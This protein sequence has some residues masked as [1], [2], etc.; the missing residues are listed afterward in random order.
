M[1]ALAGSLV[2]ASSSVAAECPEE[3]TYGNPVTPPELAAPGFPDRRLTTVEI[4]DYLATV[5]EESDRVTTDTY[6]TS[7]SGTDL[8]YALVGTPENLERVEEIAADQKRLRDPRVTDATTAGTIADENPA[9]VWYAGNIHGNETS[10]ADAAVSILYDLA[11]RTDCATERLLDELVIGI[12]PTQNPDGRD[13]F[14]RTNTYKFDMNRD[15]FAL[16]QPATSGNV[17]LL[18]AYPPVLFIDAHE[19]GSSDYFFPPNADP[20][21]HE[22]SDESL[23]WINDLYGPALADAFDERQEEQPGQWEYFSYSVYDL[24]YM[25]YGDTVPTTAFTS[26]GMTFEK[27]IAD[28]DRQR[29]VEQYV[30]GWTSLE[31]AAANKDDILREY[32][33]AHIQAIADG[34]AGRLEDNLVVQPENEVQFEVPDDPV[35]HYF[36]LEERAPATTRKLVDRLLRFGVEVHRLS[37]DLHVPDLTDYGRDPAAGTVPAGSYWVPMAQPQ[38]RWIQ[39]LLGEDPYS[40]FPYFYD[41]TSWSNP[42]LMNVEARFSGA[43]LEPSATP[44]DS[45]RAGTVTGPVKNARYF[46]FEGGSGEAV[47]AGLAAA[48]AGLDVGRVMD[49]HHEPGSGKPMPRG[50]FVV[51]VGP[52]DDPREVAARLREVVG[53][54]LVRVRAGADHPPASDAIA[55][56]RIAVHRPA[57]GAAPFVGESNGHLRF[58][59]DHVWQIPYTEL[60]GA[61]IAG[62]A[63]QLGGYDVLLVGGTTTYDLTAAREQIRAWIGSGGVYVGTARPGDTG[64]TPFAVDSGWTTSRTQRIPGA[65]ISGTI[66]RVDVDAEAGP[67]T[68]GAGDEAY[69]FN[70]GERALTTTTSGVNAVVYPD[71]PPDFF[72]S[73]FARNTDGLR[74]TA[75]LVDEALGDGRVVLFS[76]EP[77]FRAYTG[78]PA[79]FLANALAYPS[80]DIAA[81]GSDVSSS[82][83]AASVAAARASVTGEQGPGRP[84]SI[85]VDA[86]DA[87][88]ARTLLHRFTDE[89]TVTTVA[90]SAFL[91]I[92]N[93][94]DL[95][96]R[97]EHPFARRLLP[98]FERAGIDVRSALF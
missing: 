4:A 85:E 44:V 93:R 70:L 96:A 17:D 74:A 19:M 26:A 67:V 34:E 84:I 52:D 61:E 81:G 45:V 27:G 64:G 15:W 37:E 12:I 78:S 56:P 47:A 89:V 82:R 49:D 72:Y 77:T 3:A 90:G 33:H 7:W 42:L 54:F 73:G 24:F 95:D 75:G 59:L 40:P 97:E 10:G 91:E 28:T 38:K 63:L 53:P 22:I 48:R 31:T 35:R 11:A 46:W 18:N 69:W 25:G 65:Q 36:L 1:A 9:I 6:A 62:G 60:T 16:T 58:V 8:G 71:G 29:W 55:Q 87:D 50:A 86:A 79:F 66:F 43:E 41:V 88:A 57:E 92:P 21:H 32:H 39:A 76:G 14:D 51:D 30:A 68:L 98:A 83:H 5:D 20:I 94:A 2:V 80:V 13:R 23:H